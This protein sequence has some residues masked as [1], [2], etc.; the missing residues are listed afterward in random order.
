M[1]RCVFIFLFAIP[2]ISI[3]DVS[4]SFAHSINNVYTKDISSDRATISWKKDTS[5]YGDY[6]SLRSS[7]G[8]H[9]ATVSTKCND[10]SLLSTT[11]SCINVNNLLPGK[12]YLYK[13]VSNFIGDV[14]ITNTAG[15]NTGTI[16]GGTSNS[17]QVV[18]SDEFSFTTPV[19]TTVAVYPTASSNLLATI[20]S[21]LTSTASGSTNSTITLSW[22]NNSTSS[23]SI[24][25]T[26]DDD[27]S[28]ISVASSAISYTDT[29]VSPGNNYSYKLKSCN[30][31][32][33]SYSSTASVAIPQQTVVVTEVAPTSPQAISNI[34]VSQSSVSLTW[35]DASSNET[36]FEIYR[37]NTGTLSTKIKDVTTN[38][39]T[40]TDS[41][42]VSGS[43]IYS[44]SACNNVGCS[45]R[46]Y[47]SPAVAIATTIANPVELVKPSNPT[48]LKLATSTQSANGGTITTLS[49]SQVVGATSYKV[50]DKDGVISTQ[51]NTSKI[52]GTNLI[53]GTYT[54]SVVACNSDSNCSNSASTYIIIPQQLTLAT[55]TVIALPPQQPTNLRLATTSNLTGT[56]S[57]A[58]QANVT[59]NVKNNDSI[60]T[61]ASSPY[62]VENLFPGTHEYSVQA[63]ITTSGAPLCSNFVS[64]SIHIPEPTIITTPSSPTKAMSSILSSFNNTSSVAISWLDNSMN[65]VSF[66]ITRKLGDQSKVYELLKDT[67]YYSDSSLT[68]GTYTYSISACNTAGCSIPVTTSI[69]IPDAPSKN[70]S[71][72]VS[73]S[74]G[75]VVSGARV[76]AYN[77]TKSVET[78]TDISGKYS[79]TLPGGGYTLQVTQVDASDSPWVVDNSTIMISNTDTTLNFSARYLV[80]TIKAVVI[81]EFGNPI[82]NIGVVIENRN[83]TTVSKIPTQTTNSSGNSSILVNSGNYSLYTTFSETLPYVPAEYQT[84]SISN[85]EVK[86]VTFTLKKKTT[87][88]LFKLRGV[89]KFED[90]IPTGAYV[91]A[92]SDNG[93]FESV[94]SSSITG[95]FTLN[96]S[97]DDIWHISAKKDA[98]NKSYTTTEITLPKNDY[99]RTLELFFIKNNSETLP[100]SVVKKTTTSSTI[101]VEVN[102]GAGIALSPNST[103]STGVIDVEVKPTTEAPTQKSSEVISTVYDIT[104]KNNIGTN[105]TSLSSEAQITLPYN[106]DE[107]RAQGIS[108]ESLIPSYFDEKIG[109]WVSVQKYKINKDKKT[110]TL[111]V[112]HLT[113][114]ALIAAADTTAPSSPT[115]I[116][117]DAI[118]PTDVKI[119]WNNPT[120]DFNHAKIYR[121]EKPGIFGD[122][123]ATEVFSN[124]FIDKT[125]TQDKK[126]YYYTVRAVDAAG[127]ESNNINQLSLTVLGDKFAQGNKTKSLSL[128]PGQ[129][130][131]DTITRMLSAGS[132]GDDVTLLQTILKLD[133][134][135]ATGPIT[136][137]YGKLTENAVFR[138]QNYYKKEILTPN[139]YKRGTGIVG[140]ATKKKLLEVYANSN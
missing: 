30:G 80:S 55:T 21:S 108:V 40:Y 19:A 8:S 79:L 104:I 65:E 64:T 78:T 4:R 116:V 57:W 51:T 102:D 128:P 58:N 99:Q 97:I 68:S 101:N 87:S 60:R 111:F 44:V 11:T 103:N 100:S 15:A 2:L 38:S 138:F 22:K 72:V 115:N 83:T 61:N 75:K 92:W 49:W 76:Y 63:C 84:I 123:V 39:T 136:G 127:N 131:T 20:S 23:L 89:T 121:S 77:T 135:Y 41:N 113:R 54:Y 47:F 95:E 69:I 93:G 37:G 74:D 59:Y 14:V 35:K 62:T 124:S 125:F 126:T 67:Q 36:R 94:L 34:V 43:Y 118:T 33:C 129:I 86:T 88:N 10:T 132:K 26:K 122:L 112:Q 46:S 32:L 29:N 110:F 3:G 24:I 70:V 1:R 90:G 91:S 56:L 105:V 109:T 140:P 71:G 130:G 96:L 13:A 48:N 53:S 82:P 120:V 45:E 27:S 50:T 5:S 134:F 85:N 16:L 133:G 117:T 114:F 73:F 106:E 107:L 18:S 42:L 9:T 12:T 52:V 139:G 119:T 17:S 66:K 98:K 31:D 81:D 25:K 6:I 137:F 7:D 28:E